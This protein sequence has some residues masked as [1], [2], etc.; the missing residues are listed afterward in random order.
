M[1]IGYL[2]LISTSQDT[3]SGRFDFLTA[4]FANGW[5]LD[6]LQ[7]VEEE[8]T[9]SGVTGR[10]WRT[11]YDQLPEFEVETMM[12][13]TSYS[14]GIALAKSYLSARGRLASLVMTMGNLTQVYRRLHIVDVAPKVRAG[15]T[16]GAGVTAGAAA[17]IVAT[18]RLVLVEV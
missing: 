9:S 15:A 16:A 18:W 13:A 10:R 17:S 1:A 8:L 3:A 5:P 4:Q 6:A 2:T 7:H 12:D 11:I 14:E